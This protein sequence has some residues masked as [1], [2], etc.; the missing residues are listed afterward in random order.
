M[1]TAKINCKINNLFEL[2]LP[3]ELY[4]KYVEVVASRGEVI[5]IRFINKHYNILKNMI[6]INYV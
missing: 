1:I 6:T 5:T 3:I 2:G 4:D